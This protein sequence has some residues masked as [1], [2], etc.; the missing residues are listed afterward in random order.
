MN[1]EAHGFTLQDLDRFN[2]VLG[3]NGSGKS[4]LL[5]QVESR[6][7]Q[8]GRHV[9][10]LS[11]ERGGSLTYDYGIEQQIARN[12]EWLG[13]QRR[14]NQA[15]GFRQQSV[16]LFRQLER[17][18][19]LR[20]EREHT[21]PEYLPTTF[22][23]HVDR[24]NTLL[25]RVR[26]VRDERDFTIAG[27]D[28]GVDANAGNISSG[29]AEL[30]SLGIEILSFVQSAVAGA[31]NFLLIDEPDVHLHPD[32]QDRL[33]KFIV[34]SIGDKQVILI[35]ATHSTALL[36]SLAENPAIR[37]AFLRHGQIQLQFK[38][39]S[40]IDRMVLPIFGAHPL[41]NVFNNS[42]ILLLEG[43]D[44]ERVWQQAVRSAE[45][46]IRLY[47][48]AVDGLAHMSAFE[49]EV[50]A[51]V[52]AVYDHA[53]AYS[54]RDRDAQPEAINNVGR[55][56]RMRLSC[57]AA[58]NLL[59]TDDV[60]QSAGTSWLDLQAAI[61][62]WIEGNGG[63]KY[64]AEVKAF[65]DGGF[66]RKTHDL[67]DIRNILVALFSKRPWEVLVGQSIALLARGGGGAGGGSLRDF[68]GGP[69][70]TQLLGLQAN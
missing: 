5:K 51:I 23:A 62:N 31:D 39:V 32:L 17:Q 65:A 13:D 4:L 44:D 27:R 66:A 20:I 15:D 11:P 22:D 57:T 28:Q 34:E 53:R 37:V 61:A 9:R 16:A 30:V 70:C 19:L 29:E 12:P 1:V 58:E 8:E 42:P 69:V 68:L 25:D 43:E 63:H 55:V 3:K 38:P 60:L 10:Y 64:H 36:A 40:Y 41:S 48:C 47:P 46:V 33:A 54:L 59:L 21:K 6:L 14:R 49:T 45:G 18:V 50:N 7:K 2:I 35:L 52:E 26:I 24:L 67:K 56:I